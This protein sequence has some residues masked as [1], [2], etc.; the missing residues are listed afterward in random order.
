M[1]NYKLE[2]I[3][4]SELRLLDHASSMVNVSRVVETKTAL[5][6]TYSPQIP[7]WHE[8]FQAT[9]TTMSNSFQS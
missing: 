2:A 7:L 1:I 4:I 6:H 5:P 3:I 8:V 9:Q